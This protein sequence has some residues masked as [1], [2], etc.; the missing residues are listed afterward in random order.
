[1]PLVGGAREPAPV[2]TSRPAATPIRAESRVG[3]PASSVPAAPSD[4]TAAEVE[5]LRRARA[6]LRAN[7]ADDALALLTEHAH[8]AAG[9]R[10]AEERA[11]LRIETLCMLGRRDEARTEARAWARAPVGTD[12]LLAQRCDAPNR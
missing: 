9:D 7:R 3:P 8:T 12:D 4:T 10:F 1:M 5:L 6:A 11:L 2:P